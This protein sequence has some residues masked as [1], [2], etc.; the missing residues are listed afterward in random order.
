[1]KTME[2]NCN[3]LEYVN[4]NQDLIY[5]PSHLGLNLAQMVRYAQNK[6]VKLNELSLAEVEKF[7]IL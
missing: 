4:K 2:R 5:K 3:I 6:G 7:R 1:M